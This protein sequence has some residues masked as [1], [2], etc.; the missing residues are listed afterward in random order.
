MISRRTFTLAGLA[1]TTS[2]CGARSDAHSRLEARAAREG[3]LRID[4]ASGLLGDRELMNTFKRLYPGIA[5]DH[6]R[7]PSRELHAHFLRDAPRGRPTADI[8]IS[9]AMDLQFKLVND[10]FAQPYDSPEKPRLPD[11]AVWKDEAYAIAADP[12]VF[13]YNKTLMP[14]ADVPG[15]HSELT[16]LLRRKPEEYRGKVTSYDPQR[17]GTGY[18]YYTQD[19]LLSR[20]TLDLVQAVGRTQPKLYVSGAEVGDKVLRGEHLFAYNMVSSYMMLRQLQH[21]QL[22]IVFPSDYTP[23]MLRIAFIPKM[24]RHPAAGGLFL[25][26]LLSELGQVLMARQHMQPIRKGV[27]ANG[28]AP[29]PEVQRRIHFGPSLLANL[30]EFRRR[31]VLHEWRRALE[32]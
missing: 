25:D 10:G 12:L 21:P 5:L 4:V 27:P 22:G 3:A 16:D 20:D 19:L 28:P 18:L 2:G 1:W 6:H 8:L 15:S 30:D 9:S 11:W 14:P 13:A 26:F 23:V 32:S 24:A 7:A 31:R 29:S 17:S